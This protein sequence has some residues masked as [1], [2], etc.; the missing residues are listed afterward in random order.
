MTASALRAPLAAPRSRHILPGFGLSLGVT[1]TW[2][3]LLVVIPVGGLF[4]KAAGLGVA[5]ILHQLSL[6]RT[7]AAF[8]VSFGIALAAAAANG[9]IGLLVAWVLVRHRFPGRRVVDAMIDLPF[10]L[11]TAVAGITLATLFSDV[12][13]LGVLLEPLGVE[14]AFTRL[15]IFVALLFVGFPFVIRTLQPVI[16]D[17]DRDAEEAARTLGASE[18][19]IFRQVILPPL[20]PGILTGVA[21]AFARGVGEY[22]SVIFI[23]GNRPGISEI[24]PLLIVAKLEQFDYAGAAAIAAAMLVLAFLILLGIGFLERWTRRRHGA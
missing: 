7:R 13:W 5:D 19:K 16:G 3:G 14:V 23:A 9:V 11:P 6:P 22:G 2:L 24:V 8:A 20:L 1:L 12:G 18:A 17:L 10:A 4:L 21:L 15:G